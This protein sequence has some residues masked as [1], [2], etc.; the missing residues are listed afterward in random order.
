MYAMAA[1]CGIQLCTHA[2][3]WSNN[4]YSDQH[5]NPFKRC[6]G[7]NHLCISLKDAMIVHT[8][9]IDV[10]CCLDLLRRGMPVSLPAA[11]ADVPSRQLRHNAHLNIDIIH[12]CNIYAA[13]NSSVFSSRCSPCSGS[14]QCHP[15]KR[16]DEH[17]F[18]NPN[19]SRIYGV[20][21]REVCLD[22]ASAAEQAIL[23]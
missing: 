3:L 16:A 5:T 8:C 21:L 20:S 1:D 2:K 7:A 14:Y 19:P 6:M 15:C 17:H 10:H 18:D 12:V 23:P 11:S 22:M 9:L 13:V 4:G